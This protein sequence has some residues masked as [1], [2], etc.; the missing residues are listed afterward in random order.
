MFVGKKCECLPAARY[1]RGGVPMK[2][3]MNGRK[4][5]LTIWPTLRTDESGDFVVVEDFRRGQERVDISLADQ[6]VVFRINEEVVVVRMLRHHFLVREWKGPRIAGR[7]LDNDF[8]FFSQVNDGG[9]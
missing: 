2:M 3:I 8:D 6:G 5:G 4:M 7:G 9:A 1:H